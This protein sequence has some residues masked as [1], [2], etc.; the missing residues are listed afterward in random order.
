M[1]DVYSLYRL[2][3][4]LQITQID[5]MNFLANLRI[6]SRLLLLL[7]FTGLALLGLG[8][9]SIVT[10]DS[11]S[12]QATAFIDAEFESVRALS[13]VRSAVG[14][15]RRYEKDLF[16]NMGDEKETERYTKSWT[17]EVA[18]IRTAIENA[19]KV[20]HPTEAALLE[21]MQKG[22][23]NYEKGFKDIMGRL[24]RG[25]INDP[26]A[27]NAAMTPLKT[28]IRQADKSLAELTDSV[29]KRAA[30]R[31]VQ[32]A[33]TAQRAPW[34]IA[35]AT[36]LVALAAAGLALAIV[37][38]ILGPIGQLQGVT[39][40]WGQGDLSR[41]LRITGSD[42]ISAVN[43]DLNSMH[44]AL[45]RLVEQVR[46]GVHVVGANTSEIAAANNDLSERTEQAAMSLQ[47]TNASVQQLSIAVKHSADSA[48]QAV[49][50]AGGAMQVAT[51]GGRLLSGWLSL[52]VRSM[53]HRK[54]LPTSSA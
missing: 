54:K 13:D 11:G 26:W 30:E 53:L 19:K 50:S 34:V 43:R 46:S 35:V 39:R 48:Y 45:V 25:E 16:L 23:D 47:K 36:T 20:T 33:G 4:F 22:I 38:S 8:A 18:R 3:F 9:F 32:F 40:H 37:R 44:E 6:R 42:E 27:A 52:W 29:Q 41:K 5:A 21:S 31:R 12:A 10:I 51:K 28:D 2:A 17:E 24:A 15:A 49:Q 1:N 14:N 7:A